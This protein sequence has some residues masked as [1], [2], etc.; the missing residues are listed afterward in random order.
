MAALFFLR[1]IQ[2]VLA[3]T[4]SLRIAIQIMTALEIALGNKLSY[5]LALYT[6]MQDMEARMKH[7]VEET[8]VTLNLRGNLFVVDTKYLDIFFRTLIYS[9]PAPIRGHY[10]IDR[11]FEGFDRIMNAMRG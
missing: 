4:D 1:L 9:D 5:L 2:V 11:P 8:A 3:A 10:I 6:H 7:R